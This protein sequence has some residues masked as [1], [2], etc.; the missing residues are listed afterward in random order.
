MSTY[1]AN[2]KFVPYVTYTIIGLCV[3]IFVAQQFMRVVSIENFAMNPVAIG[4]F[5]EYYRLPTSMFMHIG[6]MHIAFNMLILYLL[7]PALERAL[8]SVRFAVLYMLAGLG[9][10]VTSYVLSSPGTF[11]V[12]ASGAIYGLMGAALIGGKVL[13]I[14][15]KQVLILIGINLAISFIP[16]W[17]IDWRAHVGGLVVGT[18]TAWVF[19]QSFAPRRQASAWSGVAVDAY[20]YPI[21]TSMQPATPTH[22]L[23]GG[24]QSIVVRQVLGCIGIAAVLILATMW[25]SNQLN[26][27]ANSYQVT[28]SQGAIHQTPTA[29]SN[30]A[31]AL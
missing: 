17:G 11:S 15:V 19:Q 12:G 1:L 4:V 22:R 2:K 16:G 6:F 5:G 25:R 29:L 20:G 13:N 26:N 28:S 14:D 31:P 3:V 10:A 9:G 21:A 27:Q 7:G 8:G 23:T 18:A 24:Q 30:N